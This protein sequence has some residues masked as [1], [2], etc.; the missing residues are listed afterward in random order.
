MIPMNSDVLE[1]FDIAA[2]LGGDALIVRA[3]TL[4]GAFDE[5]LAVLANAREFHRVELPA[6]SGITN[7]RSLARL[8]AGL[9]GPVDGGPPEAILTREQVHLARTLQTSGNDLRSPSPAWMWKTTNCTRLLV[10]LAVA[11]MGGAGAFGDF[12]AGGSVGFADPEHELAGGYV[13]TKMGLGAPLDPR[14]GTP[15]FA[16]ATT[17]PVPRSTHG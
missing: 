15:S 3:M 16:P 13:M 8:Y 4:N 11:P 1:G 9:I 17:R 12:G 5:D 10:G 7:A 2:A 6:V 14:A